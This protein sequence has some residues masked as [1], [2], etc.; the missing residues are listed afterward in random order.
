MARSHA[1]FESASFFSPPAAGGAPAAGAEAASTAAGLSSACRGLPCFVSRASSAFLTSVIK[2]ETVLA[3][4]LQASADLEQ[5]S[6]SPAAA[7]EAATK[8]K[9]HQ[10]AKAGNI[11][12]IRCFIEL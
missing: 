2:G 11:F 10:S 4:G 5:S 12:F 1:G 6:S 8:T 7:G 9:E 3:D